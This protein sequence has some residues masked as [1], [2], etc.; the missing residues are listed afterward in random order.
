[1][2]NQMEEALES[3]ED[4]EESDILVDTIGLEEDDRKIREI[5]ED[6]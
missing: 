1:M 6:E 3:G 5:E 2:L 4:L